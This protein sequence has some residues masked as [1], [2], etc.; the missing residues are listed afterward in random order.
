MKLVDEL[1]VR[2]FFRG[3]STGLAPLA[4]FASFALA[5]PRNQQLSLIYYAAA[6][7]E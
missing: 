3:H 2:R 7:F 1:Q 5:E 6:S 4:S